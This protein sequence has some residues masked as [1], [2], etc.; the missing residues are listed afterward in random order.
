[1]KRLVSFLAVLAIVGAAATLATAGDEKAAKSGK[2]HAAAAKT[3][4]WTGEI[5]DAGCYIG[6]GASGAKHAECA[7]KCAANGMPLMLLTKEGKAV[8][9]TPNHD[10]PDAYAQLKTMA[11]SMATVTGSLAERGGVRGID[12]TGVTAVA[13]ATETK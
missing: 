11:G 12:V 13:A 2:S 4:S 5:L 3:G 6:H 10:N 7:L 9:L 1:M 8:L